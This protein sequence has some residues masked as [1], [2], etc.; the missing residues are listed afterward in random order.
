MLS[1]GDL[2]KLTYVLS[3]EC[4]RKLVEAWRAV[5]EEAGIVSFL[6]HHGFDL[7]LANKVRKIWPGDALT[8]LRRIPIG[9]WPSPAGRKW[10]GWRAR[11]GRGP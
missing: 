9:C 6:D 2:E 5:S 10:T 4:A 11:S 3:E 7:R 1:Q 8:K